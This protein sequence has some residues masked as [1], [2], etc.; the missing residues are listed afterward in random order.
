MRIS[1]ATSP[2]G[3]GSA[4]KQP[5]PTAVNTGG[6]GLFTLLWLVFVAALIFDPARLDAVWSWS[7]DLPVIAQVVGWVL[8]LPLMIGLAI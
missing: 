7:R 5:T 6:S 3:A 4:P 8:L 1:P 2:P